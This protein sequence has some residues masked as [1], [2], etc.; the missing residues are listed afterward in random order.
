MA[1]N[2]D[3]PQNPY[4][5]SEVSFVKLTGIRPIE[6]TDVIEGEVGDEMLWSSES[7]W[8]FDPPRIPIDGDEIVI[9]STSNIILDIPASEAPK[10]VG[11]EINGALTFLND[12]TADRA[13]RAHK[14][15]VRAGTLNIGNATH[16][17]TNNAEIELLG[18]NT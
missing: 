15:W 10:L 13:I 11:L 17:F 1:V 9:N 2:A 5:A 4:A 16:P 7:S 14:M 3:T 12:G 8:S 6:V 18:D